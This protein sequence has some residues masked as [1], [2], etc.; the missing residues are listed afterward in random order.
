MSAHGNR[1]LEWMSSVMTEL[2]S[3]NV[4]QLLQVFD[5]EIGSLISVGEDSSSSSKLFKAENVPLAFAT[6]GPRIN[7]HD[8]QNRSPMAT[9][10]QL[11]KLRDH[12]SIKNIW[13]KETVCCGMFV[14]ARAT[15]CT[16]TAFTTT[17]RA[18]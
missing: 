1:V 14:Q 18:D 6:R 8:T 15:P 2:S 4:V 16:E 12:Q 13:E 3:R 9:A 17:F 10:Q 11:I 7:L 5:S